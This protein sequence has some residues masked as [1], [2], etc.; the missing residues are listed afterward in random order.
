MIR[1]EFFDYDPFTGITEYYE[2]HGDGT[3]SL[4]S[5]QDVSRFKDVAAEL[6]NGGHAD[7]AWA[8]KGATVY[9]VIPP[10]IQAE[11]F[12]KGINFLDPNATKRVVDEI[13]KNYPALKTTYKHHELKR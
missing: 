3:V 2:E 12:K 6:R 7:A 1:G 11:L 13:N 10:I 4:H 8:E 9:A 5:Y